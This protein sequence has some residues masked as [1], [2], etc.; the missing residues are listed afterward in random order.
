V[1]W[2]PSHSQQPSLIANPAA[3]SEEK[4][5]DVA[6][7]DASLI[8]LSEGPT[9]TDDRK[10][11]AAAKVILTGLPHPT[12]KEW[13]YLT[14][15]LNILLGLLTLDMIIRGP[16]LYPSNDLRFTRVGY[17]E[18]TSAKVLFREP[19]P[20]QLPVYVYYQR[21]GQS[22]WTTADKIYFLDA[23]SD[24]TYPITFSHLSP[25]STYTYSLSNNLTGSFTTAP[26]SRE[27]RKLSFVTSSCIKANFPYNP[28]SHPLSIPG[29]AQ[30]S[31]VLSS[32]PSPAAF[33]LFLGDFIY[34]DVPLRL[35]SSTPHY[36]SE[37]RRV[38]ASPSW[39]LPGLANLPWLHTLDDHEIAN[40]WSAGNSTPPFPA[41]RDPFLNYHVSVNPPT[42]PS[43]PPAPNTTY[44]TFTRGPA[45]FFM[46][47]TR[48][49]RTAPEPNPNATM[50]GEAQLSSLLSYL[51]NPEPDNVHWK[52]VASSVPFTKNWR[53]GTRDTWG[54]FLTERSI[55]LAAMHEA[56]SCLG[57][58]VVV[59]SGDRHEFGAIR[60]PSNSSSSSP[61][62]GPH[63]FA[64]G[65]LSMFYLPFRTFR[66][67]DDEDVAI[68]YL[69]DGNSKIGAIEMTNLKGVDQQRSLMKY[70]LYVDGKVAW[71]YMLTSP[72]PEF[73]GYRGRVVDSLWS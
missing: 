37:H 8:G 60:F 20:K 53:F 54:G 29:F 19:D 65:P 58:R 1:Y 56:E 57:V 3:L 45:S 21:E 44:F 48:A 22:T 36:R 11:Y 47:D 68:K 61:T 31:R 9:T 24:F 66:Q 32:L 27:D 2:D 73:K 52:I 49:Y 43:S 15:A 50:L 17:V 70:S 59:L 4:P 6:A 14:I 41:A 10:N 34:V 23:D 39:S 25:S 51:S 26:F 33:M 67:I 7:D 42:P 63:E 35:S 12:L 16:L 55:I 5:R 38:Y 13:S 40:D 64:V 71:E 62:S 46:L 18:S 28:L 72:P 30:L 69:P